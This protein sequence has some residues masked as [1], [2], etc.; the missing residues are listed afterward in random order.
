M[1]SETITIRVS[2]EVARMFNSASA[3]QRRKLEV[4]MSLPLLDWTK[5]NESL[6][7]AKDHESWQSLF[8][9]LDQFSDDFMLER[10]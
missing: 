2:P 6:E 1:E 8:D 5:H 3:E 10:E 7:T 9:S 4:I